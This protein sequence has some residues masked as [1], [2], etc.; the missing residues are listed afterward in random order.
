MFKKM[1][2]FGWIDKRHN[3]YYILEG[4]F[5]DQDARVTTPSSHQHASP[6]PLTFVTK[7]N[8]NLED[9]QVCSLVYI[10][11][12]RRD[13]YRPVQYVAETCVE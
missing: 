9:P 12:G 11:K 1:D 5:A 8:M 13:I 7:K 4:S 3:S 2:F 10:F 6:N